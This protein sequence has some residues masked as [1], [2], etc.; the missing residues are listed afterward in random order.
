MLIL[1]II[2][3]ITYDNINNNNNNNDNNN[4]M[5]SPYLRVPRAPFLIT[6]IPLPGKS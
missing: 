1:T 4:D 3:N 5:C 6:T 2:Y